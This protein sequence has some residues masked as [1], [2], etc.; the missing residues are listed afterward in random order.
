MQIHLF[1][2]WLEIQVMLLF[3]KKKEST[4]KKRAVVFY[5]SWNIMWIVF[6]FSIQAYHHSFAKYRWKLTKK[7]SG[8]GGNRSVKSL[9]YPF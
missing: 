8:V 3:G 1:L 7:K 5:F 6:N 2:D 9:F 4:K